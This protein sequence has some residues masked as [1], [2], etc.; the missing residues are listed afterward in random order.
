MCRDVLCGRA[1]NHVSRVLLCLFAWVCL[2]CFQI[3]EA[4][5]DQSLPQAS[6]QA[7][8]AAASTALR[9]LIRLEI[10]NPIT[11]PVSEAQRFSYELVLSPRQ[12]ARVAVKQNGADVSVAV[13]SSENKRIANV[14]SELRY[15]GEEHVDLVGD[16]NND[17]YTINVWNKTPILVGTYEIRIEE[18]RPATEN[19]RILHQAQALHTEAFDLYFPR[20]NIK[21]AQILAERSLQLFESVEGPDGLMVAENLTTLGWIHVLQARLDLAEPLLQRTLQIREKVLGPQHPLVAKSLTE[22]AIYWERRGYYEKTEELY[23]KALQIKE[24]AYGRD[25]SEIGYAINMLANLQAQVGNYAAAKPLYERAL[26]IREKIVGPNSLRIAKLQQELADVYQNEGNFAMAESLYRKSLVICEGIQG[27]EGDW[28]SS[29]KTLLADLYIANG[30]YEKARL[31]YEQVLEVRKRTLR[32]NHQAIGY[33][34]FKLG[35]LSFKTGDD[36]RAEQLYKEAIAIW[37]TQ[38]GSASNYPSIAVALRELAQIFYQ[39]R[40]YIQAEGALQRAL[41]VLIAVNGPESPK[42]GLILEQL[43]SIHYDQA[44]YDQAE[45]LCQR[46]LT[47]LQNANGPQHPSVARV[48][49]ILTKIYLARGQIARALDVQTQAGAI[50]DRNLA[51]NLAAGTERW[52]LSYLEALSNQTSRIISLH[53]LFASSNQSA[54]RLAAIAVLQRKGRVQDAMSA[55]LDAL[56]GRFGHED[57]A[58]LDQLHT[59]TAQ[60]AR[61]LFDGPGRMN[62]DE[63]RQRIKTADQQRQKVEEE[64]S[65]HSAGYYELSRP[66]SLSQVQSAIPANAA[67]IEFAVYRPFNPK[68]PADLTAYAEPHY[69]AYII[70]NHGAVQWRELGPTKEIDQSI[71]EWRQALRDPKRKDV[72]ALARLVDSRVL[73]PIRTSLQDVN[74]LLVSPDGELN[75]IPFACLRDEYGKYLVE[76]YEVTYLTSGRELLRTNVARSS[77]TEPVIFADPV[78][79]DSHFAK[80][81]QAHATRLKA[82]VNGL[83]VKRRKPLEKYSN[84][85]FVPLSGTAEEARSIQRLFPDATLLTAD[86]ATESAMKQLN[87]PR[88]LHIATHG[89]FLAEP[90][91]VIDTAATLTKREAQ[92]IGMNNPLL[93]SGLALAGANVRSGRDDGI[94][95][96]LEATAINL[97]GT[98]L[99]VLSACDTGIGEVRTGEGV[100]GLRRAFALAGAETVV[101]SLWPASDY[102]SRKFM[103]SYYT[104]LK[105][106]IGRGAA[107]RRVQLDMLSRNKQLHPFYWANFIQSGEWANLDGTR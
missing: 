68:A 95:T 65:R 30:D 50:E 49:D 72:Q 93:R 96:A 83:T 106:G 42:V 28:V 101:M 43:A 61:L 14:D 7:S 35:T 44:H 91:T 26:E 34:L 103:T 56:R 11:A 40:N 52:K 21:K 81:A 89:F 85:L 71:Y 82:K 98:K 87:A 3:T 36:V 92:S 69:V 70:R 84:P 63:Y 31:L 78:F 100:Y 16:A 48:L 55:S 57:Q 25:H 104:H 17:H 2:L 62:L 51:L 13:L 45:S 20:T 73:Q 27:P 90:P 77:K 6:A 88:I 75:L 54:V 41:T 39:R 32:P 97:W 59:T 38:Q 4:A 74:Q 107:L 33:S 37:E 67:L 58:L 80:A 66:V 9:K 79:G 8:P 23:L 29:T 94:L 19:E 47:V 24:A 105:E 18:L 86:A 76:R 102:T 46:A 99:V 10:G 53:T 60:L 1:S 64:I 5:D 15:F 22:L 12:F